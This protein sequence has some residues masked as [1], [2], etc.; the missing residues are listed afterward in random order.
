MSWLYAFAMGTWLVGVK[1]GACGL[2]WI[3]TVLFHMRPP[4][5]QHLSSLPCFA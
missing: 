4:N 3:T 1:V 2:R 5:L